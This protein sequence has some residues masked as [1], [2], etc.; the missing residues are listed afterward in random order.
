[1]NF[2]M[3]PM[4][5]ETGCFRAAALSALLVLAGCTNESEDDSDRAGAGKKARPVVTEPVAFAAE[6][7]RIE[8][9]GTA[10]ARHSIV[11]EPA[12][13]GQVNE[14]NFQTG[15]YVEEGQVLL[16]L[17]DRDERLAVQV[18]EV[19][20]ANAKRALDRYQRSA[21]SGGITESML[22]EAA[23]VVEQAELALQRARVNL[24]YHTIRAPFSGHIGMTELD[25]GA[26]VDPDTAIA[27]L[28]D[29]S[30]LLVRFHLPEMLF[31]KLPL[32]ERVQLKSW[33]DQVPAVEG[34]IVEVGTR[35]DEARRSFPLRARVENE[36]DQLRPGMSFRIQLT[37]PG[38][39]YPLIPELSV[40]WGGEGAYIWTVEDGKAKRVMVNVVQRQD[41]GVLVDA[42]LAEGMPIVTEGVHL[43]RAGMAVRVVNDG[44]EDADSPQVGAQL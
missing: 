6:Q 22:D 25:A 17:D 42:E 32:G 1:M 38:N 10:R 40:Q 23:S 28:D 15:D 13:T 16:R 31:G 3:L 44:Q 14:I 18:A 9:V 19:E 29:R 39:R 24:E 41:A 34:E 35:I 8:A 27:T 21:R 30:S 33:G 4:F 11:L 36:N 26:W 12:V 43:V 20:L 7:A 2:F 37:L 5:K